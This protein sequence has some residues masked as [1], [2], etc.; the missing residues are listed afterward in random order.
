MSYGSLSLS[1]HRV[2]VSLLAKN[3]FFLGAILYILFGNFEGI[4]S[5]S[6]FFLTCHSWERITSNY[7]K[8]YIIC[9]CTN[10]LYTQDFHGES[11]AKESACNAGNPGSIPGWGIS[12]EIR[13]G[14]PF[15][16]SCL[17]N[18]MNRGAGWAT[19]H[20]SLRE[21]NVTEWLTLSLHFSYYT[22]T[23]AQF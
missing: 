7:V 4:L 5:I 9:V 12:P 6:S 2:E 13:N 19:V 16:H 3:N 17:E 15:Q 22:H 10:T 18:S 23:H 1:D 14:C 11:Y 8:N 20:G 21:A